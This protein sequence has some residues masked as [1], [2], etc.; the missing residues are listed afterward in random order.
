MQSTKN[1]KEKPRKK[2]WK[3]KDPSWDTQTYGAGKSPFNTE[4]V[5]MEVDG[6]TKIFFLH[7]SKESGKIVKITEL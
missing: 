4:W 3:T 7:T 6:E 2:K 5:K 1:I